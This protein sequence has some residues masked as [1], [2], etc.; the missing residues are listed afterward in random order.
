[1]QLTPTKLIINTLT[2]P[3]KSRLNTPPTEPFAY[4]FACLFDVLAYLTLID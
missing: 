1:M 3:D 2:K 4:D